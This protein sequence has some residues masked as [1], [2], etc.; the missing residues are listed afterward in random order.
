VNDEAPVPIARL[1]AMA[2]RMLMD[3]LHREL[4]DRGWTDVRPAFGF[5]LLA[6][7]DEPTTAKQLGEL[8]GTTKQAASK[9]LDVM[10][11]SGYIRRSVGGTDARRRE[12]ELTAQGRRLLVAV[13]GIYDEL[14]S[15]WVDSIGER[16]VD[17]LRHDLTR[18]LRDRNEGALPPV[19]PTW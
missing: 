18:V 11:E 2:Y 17:R 13:E 16:G 19:R 6:T 10:E 3:D 8:M 7:R 15:A 12:A 1:L 5:V 4:R 9:L 14:E